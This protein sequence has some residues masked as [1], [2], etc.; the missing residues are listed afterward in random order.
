MKKVL[1]ICLGNICRS[2]MAE[3]IMKDI[4]RKNGMEEDFYIESA[5]TS[6][7][8]L[9]HDTHLMA[10]VELKMHGVPVSKRA[11]RQINKSDYEKFDY[12]I[13][14]DDS[15]KRDILKIMGGDPENKVH[16]L[17]DFTARP[18]VVADPWYTDNFT[19]A[20][21]DIKEGVEGF[22]EEIS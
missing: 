13:C 6:T 19:L 16:R 18:G 21:N 15:N 4:V 5:A 22:L 8:E 14:M 1:F 20:Y 7:Y 11:A 10:Q 17:M 3:F 12:L 9:G 2:P